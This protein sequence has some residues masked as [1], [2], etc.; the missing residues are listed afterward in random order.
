VGCGQATERTRRPVP[1][2]PTPSV[3]ISDQSGHRPYA[4]R[5]RALDHPHALETWLDVNATRFPTA[6]ADDRLLR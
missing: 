3:Q 6:S 4:N 1:T 2:R 5:D